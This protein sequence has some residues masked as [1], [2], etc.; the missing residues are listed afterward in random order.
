MFGI[1]WQCYL[2]YSNVTSKNTI[3]CFFTLEVF[4]CLWKATEML[5]VT[6]ERIIIE[7]KEKIWWKYTHFCRAESPRGRSNKSS[8]HEQV[9]S[10]KMLHNRRTLILVQL[11]HILPCHVKNWNKVGKHHISYNV[12]D[13]KK[14]T[15][16]LTHTTDIVPKCHVTTWPEIKERMYFNKSDKVAAGRLQV[17]F[18]CEKISHVY[19]SKYFHHLVTQPTSLPHRIRW[20][21]IQKLNSTDVLREINTLTPPTTSNAPPNQTGA[22][23]K[24]YFTYRNF[25]LAEK[26]KLQ[27]VWKSSCK[28]FVLS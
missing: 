20:F 18:A 6:E 25:F 27:F 19:T 9:L 3:I 16:D 22:G 11:S 28:N 2:H 4:L 15:V 10:S 8:G 5:T 21:N 24:K 1:S 23:N 14:A 17:K 26:R 13:G 7:A 12:V